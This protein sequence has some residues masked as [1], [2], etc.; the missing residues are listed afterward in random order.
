MEFTTEH[1][2]E[3]DGRWLAEI[4]ELPG[5]MAYGVDPSDA[6][7]RAKALALRVVADSLEHHETS[8]KLDHISFATS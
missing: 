4:M 2:R 6:I 3:E 1:E 7:A 8:E 5:V